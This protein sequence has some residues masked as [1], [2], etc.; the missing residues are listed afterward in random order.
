MKLICVSSRASMLVQ[1]LVALLTLAALLAFG[2]R[3]MR[4]AMIACG[5]LFAALFIAGAASDAAKNGIVVTVM[6]S[7]LVALAVLGA[8][9]LV[10][11][12]KNRET[13][14]AADSE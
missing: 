11:A 7:A 4:N 6:W 13:A 8:C 12:L 2:R 5:L 14:M 3:N 10:Q 9:A 1:S